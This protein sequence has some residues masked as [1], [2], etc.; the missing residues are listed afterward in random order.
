MNHNDPIF[1]EIG[2]LST[3]SICFEPS[4]SI[5]F[6]FPNRVIEHKSH[7]GSPTKQEPLSSTKK[8]LFYIYFCLLWFLNKYTPT[9]TANETTK[10]THWTIWVSKKHRKKSTFHNS[11]G[12]LW[13]YT[14]TTMPIFIPHWNHFHLYVSRRGNNNNKISCL[15]SIH[16]CRKPLRIMFSWLKVEHCIYGAMSWTIAV[17]KHLVFFRRFR[18]CCCCCCCQGRCHCIDQCSL[19]SP[20]FSHRPNSCNAK[21]TIV[22]SEQFLHK[23]LIAE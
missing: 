23:Y 16:I 5:R 11:H 1:I 20:Y 15:R 6:G 19:F 17:C 9:K 10:N 21:D 14:V 13:Y 18:V 4:T 7:M 3:S 22:N 2:I 12:I 8:K